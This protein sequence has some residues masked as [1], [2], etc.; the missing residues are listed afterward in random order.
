MSGRYDRESFLEYTRTDVE[1]LELECRFAAPQLSTTRTSAYKFDFR[2][3]EAIQKLVFLRSQ[4]EL[5]D[6]P[7]QRQWL[8]LEYTQTKEKVDKIIDMVSH[9]LSASLVHGLEAMVKKEMY[10]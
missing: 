2:D 5:V 3:T 8:M 4:L 7:T 9:A 6:D 10:G 1:Y